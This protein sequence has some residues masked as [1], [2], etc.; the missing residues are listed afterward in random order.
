M[1]LPCHNAAR[2]C[3]SML[4]RAE[5]EVSTCTEACPN[6]DA[7]SEPDA[8]CGRQSGSDEHAGGVAQMETVA[9]SGT[10]CYNVACGFGRCW[11]SAC[12]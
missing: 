6:M 4:D 2:K 10:L 7:F 11:L 1:Q 9:A 12:F 8:E 3:L 5:E